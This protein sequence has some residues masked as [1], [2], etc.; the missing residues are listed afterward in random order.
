MTLSSLFVGSQTED[1][2]TAGLTW[3]RA[4]SR[5]MHAFDEEHLDQLLGDVRKLTTELHQ[6]P[7]YTINRAVTLIDKI[8]LGVSQDN[9][10]NIALSEMEAIFALHSLE[11]Y[12][13]DAAVTTNMLRRK[14]M[15][16]TYHLA[17]QLNLSIRERA[18]DMSRALSRGPLP[19]LPLHHPSV[20]LQRLVTAVHR[21]LDNHKI[22]L[23]YDSHQILDTLF[24][25]PT[26]VIHPPRTYKL[27][28]RSFY[29]GDRLHTRTADVV[30]LVLRH[31]F[32]IPDSPMTKD[33]VAFIGALLRTLGYSSL[34]L[35]QVWEVYSKMPS[36]ASSLVAGDGD[37]SSA[38]RFEQ[39]LGSS[40][41][42]VTSSPAFHKLYSLG[43]EYAAFTRGMWD[44]A[45]KKHVIPQ[46]S[47]PARNLVDSTFSPEDLEHGSPR[48]ESSPVSANSRAWLKRTWGLLS[49]A[50]KVVN[51]VD[52]GTAY[53]QELDAVEQKLRD[54]GD[55][56]QPFRELG[57]SRSL[58]N[59]RR[60]TAGTPSLDTFTTP[61][62]TFSVILMRVVLFRSPYLRSTVIPP[63]RRRTLFTDPSDFKQHMESLQ[64][65]YP[66]HIQDKE[67]FFCSRG[68]ISQ[69]PLN[70]RSTA[71]VDAT[72]KFV[73]HKRWIE[74]LAAG[75][76]IPFQQAR[77]A[78]RVIG[79]EVK[80]GS[81][82]PL[83]CYLTLADLC[84]HGVVS[85]PSVAEMAA[86]V[87]VL[88]RGARRGLSVCGY[89][90]EGY[91]LSETKLKP[92]AGQVE[93][94]FS[95]FY[96]G[97]E[98]GL[99]DAGIATELWNPVVAEHTLCKLVRLKDQ[100]I[101]RR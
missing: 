3:T 46:A 89:L 10:L 65:E 2:D 66:N 41:I 64:S 79:R 78:M 85:M 26:P 67:K 49:S 98:Q 70:T 43:Q 87:K 45:H 44:V 7:V 42:H 38:S 4:E 84:S 25:P 57:P 17:G 52:A 20:L 90:P 99:V 97:V 1:V 22:A 35:P 11:R 21:D 50:L 30:V 94:A 37:S 12:A 100:L 29:L 16:C 72:W 33:R 48:P 6:L 80:L 24:D 92:A 96:V 56:Y 39:V 13:L 62:G 68:A 51:A 61:A 23:V 76:P 74:L 36:W 82:G 86:Q 88:A 54:D 19:T 47:A 8:N 63:A 40:T 27:L 59:G 71:A 32:Q 93:K 81:F 9:G 5:F 69:R 101:A 18:M 91:Q 83:T 53:A 95:E 73:H 77:T 58:I 55:Y 28:D 14:I 15:A 60:S 34:L 75:V 31:W